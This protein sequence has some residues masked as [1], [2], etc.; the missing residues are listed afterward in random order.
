MLCMF[1]SRV[2]QLLGCDPKVGRRA[3]LVKWAV[4]FFSFFLIYTFIEKILGIH[5][6]G[7]TIQFRNFYNL[8]TRHDKKKKWARLFVE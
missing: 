4:S 5:F 2:S 1:I 7:H 6:G 8:L 3:V